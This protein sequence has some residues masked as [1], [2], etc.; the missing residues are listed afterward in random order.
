M[1]RYSRRGRTVWGEVRIVF[2]ERYDRDGDLWYSEGDDRWYLL[3]D[4]SLPRSL[5]E[6]TEL[7]GPMVEVY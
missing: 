5:A 6:L 4:R 7:W 2:A 1:R 3:G